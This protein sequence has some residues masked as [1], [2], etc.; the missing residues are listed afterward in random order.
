MSQL[1]DITICVEAA[2]AGVARQL[3]ACVEGGANMF[4]RAY[5]NGETVSGYISAGPVLE[6]FAAVLPIK[7]FNEEGQLVGQS[8]LNTAYIIALAGQSGVIVTH[9]VLVDL[10][11]HVDVSTQSPDAVMDRL[12]YQLL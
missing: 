2:Y 5:G 11:E 4:T 1:V 12:G 9:Q 7:T 10:F 3:C 8:A 6:E